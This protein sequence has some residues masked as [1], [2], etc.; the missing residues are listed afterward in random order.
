MRMQMKLYEY[1][2][3]A[4]IDY[5]RSILLIEAVMI[6]ETEIAQMAD[7]YIDARI[8]LLEAG[9]AYYSYDGVFFNLHPKLN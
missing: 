8:R 3:K 9:S 4:M 5:D 1:L 6:I 2:L 7:R